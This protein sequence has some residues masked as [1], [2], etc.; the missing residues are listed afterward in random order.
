[1]SA[2]AASGVA[3]ATAAAVASSEALVHGYLIMKPQEFIKLLSKEENTVVILVV[4][5]AGVL[6][7]KVTY[8]YAATYGG[9]TIL[10][11]TETPLP[12][13]SDVEIVRAEDLIVPP[14]VTSRLNSLSK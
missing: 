12:L 13:P 2:G 8:T 6:H 1:M 4:K 14:A 10:T 7:K 9:F 11:K 5:Q 3:G